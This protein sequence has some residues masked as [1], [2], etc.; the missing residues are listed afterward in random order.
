MSHEPAALAEGAR[1]AIDPICKMKVDPAAPRGGSFEFQGTTYFFCNPKCN[2]RFAADPERYLAPEWKG[3]K[4]VKAPPGARYV[5]PMDPEIDEPQ[6][7]ACRICGMALEP[8]QITAEPQEDPELRLMTRRLLAASAFALPLLAL[9]MGPMLAGGAGGLSHAHAHQPP[10]GSALAQAILATGAMV[11]G[12]ELWRRGLRSFIAR[13]L[14]MFSLI[15]LGV[16][17]AYGFSAAV[18]IARL[19]GH[20]GPGGAVGMYFESAAVITALVLLGQVLELRARQQTGE[21]LRGLLSLLP[22]TARRVFLDGSERDVPLAEIFPGHR[23][24]V[25]PGQK[26]PADG[27][28]LEGRSSLDESMLSGESLPVEKHAGARVAA[29]TINGAGALLCRVTGAGEDTLLM[30]I[31]R[32]VGAAQRSRA[33]V[34]RLAD[35]ASAY[36]VPAV[37]LVAVL[38][39]GGWLL[40]GGPALLGRG[41]LS[42]VA[43][44]IIACPCALGLATPMSILVATGRGAQAG[45]LVR[46]AEAMER[47]ARVDTLVLDKTGT[48]TAGRPQLASLLP[49][50][51]MAEA[52]LLRIAASLE[53]GSEHP[54]AGA[55]LAAAAE[56]QIE[57]AAVDEVRAEAG[58]G[59]RGRVEDRA[60]LLGTAELFAQDGVAIPEGAIAAAE[61]RQLAGQTVVHVAVAGAWIGALGIADPIKPS[62][63]AAVA[64]LAREGLRLLVASGDSPQVAAGVARSLSLDEKDVHA[65][66][67]PADKAALVRRLQQEG[68]VV[69]MAGDGVNDAP[70]LAAADVGVAMGGGTDLAKQSAGLTLLHG[71]LRALLRARRLSRATL[72]NIRQNLGLAF[73]YNALGVPIAAG[74]L[75]PILGPG[76]Q[77]SPMLASAAM[78]LSSVCVIANALRL[79]R[80]EL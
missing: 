41:L 26:V 46:S 76:W 59:L 65:K 48:L 40:A 3:T 45:I 68:R 18:L 44:L 51:G 71:D 72:R 31:V 4:A 52:E 22:Q 56:R 53:R 30:Q 77:L 47:L 58:R 64:E 55:V 43:V 73:V 28:V 61:Q 70:A 49:A 50:P 11:A 29:G 42:A 17:A 15:T 13:Q 34:Q 23:V 14:N 60:V 54:L 78:S 37:L 7:G 32:L 39:L 62:T 36:F 6:A 33:P 24:R 75:V 5:C 69:A 27:V 8:D 2:A 79:R 19:L 67:L 74:A 35:R 66:L 16:F 63:P 21:A 57:L 25:L 12:A 38:A 10:L 1:F 20:A 9:E 80:L